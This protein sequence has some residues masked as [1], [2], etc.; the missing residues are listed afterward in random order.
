MKYYA[1]H[2]TGACRS[3]ADKT[4]TLTHAVAEMVAP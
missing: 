1:M 4:S 3:G 2:L